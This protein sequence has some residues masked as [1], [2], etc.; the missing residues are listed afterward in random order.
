[1]SRKHK[2]KPQRLVVSLLDIIIPVLDMPN[3][4]INCLKSIPDA[5]GD[6]S[7]QVII[8]DNGSTSENIKQYREFGKNL[9]GDKLHIL[10][11]HRNLGFPA[12][13][14]RGARFGY[15]PLLFFLNDDVVLYPNSIE[16]LVRVMDDPTVGAVGMKLIFPPDSTD[17]RRP[18]GKVQHVGLSTNIRGEFI[19]NFVG[20]NP[21]NPRV[22]RIKDSYAIT[23][24][25][26]MTRKSLF[27]QVKGLNEE[28]GM[29]TY[30]DVE[31]CL[32]LRDMGYNIRIEQ[33]AIGEHFVGATAMDKQIQYPLQHNRMLLME[34][35]NNNLL[36]T[37]WEIW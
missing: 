16:K 17:P 3:L 35:R 28:F 30:E 36:Y 2:N 11:Q 29:G 19:H 9:L 4:L 33:E 27:K 18:A 13:I 21:D 37:E 32:T 12:A 34:H 25:A 31:Y 1:L 20:W 5:A 7:F 15:S 22:L 8:V 23:G 10:E 14:N 6:L 26:M 24:A